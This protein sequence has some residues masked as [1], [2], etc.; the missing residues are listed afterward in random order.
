MKGKKVSALRERGL[1]CDASRGAEPPIEAV[2]QLTDTNPNNHEQPSN[3]ERKTDTMKTSILRERQPVQP[4]KTL[5]PPR[6]KPAALLGRPEATAQG[7]SLF[8]GFGFILRFA[9]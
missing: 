6:P 5:R 2:S 4:Q 7:P 3:I 9:N 8:I 1:R